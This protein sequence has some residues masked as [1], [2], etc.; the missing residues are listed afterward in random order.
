LSPCEAPLSPATLLDYWLGE[1]PVAA[2]RDA[3]EHLTSCSTCS[4]G[5][6]RLAKLADGVKDLVRRG[7]LSLMLTPALLQQLERDGLRIRHHHVLPGDR[8]HCTAGP[9]DDL[10]AMWLQGDFRPDEQVDLVFLD[11]PGAMGE[12]RENVPV[13][14]QRG[15]VG[16]AEPGDV[17]RPLPAHVGVIRLYGR[18]PAGERTI[19]DYTLIHTPW[20]GS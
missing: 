9:D 3:E 10:I 4:L 5:A 7:R 8:T 2:E 1:L 14:R 19:G 17:I 15:Q 6:A 18:G 20:P 13:D 11:A 12:R 16:F